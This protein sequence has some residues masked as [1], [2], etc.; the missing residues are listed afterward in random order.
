MRGASLFQSRYKLTR[1]DRVCWA[2]LSPVWADMDC[3]M[4]LFFAARTVHFFDIR[5]KVFSFEVEIPML[6]IKT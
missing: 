2:A 1:Q 5:W 4:K 3:H 6:S